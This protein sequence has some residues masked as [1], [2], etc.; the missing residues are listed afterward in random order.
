MGGEEGQ[1]V[2]RGNS[3]RHKSSSDGER[4][5]TLEH[6]NQFNFAYSTLACFRMGMWGSAYSGAYMS[7]GDLFLA[8]EIEVGV[9][10]RAH[11]DD[12]GKVS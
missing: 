12:G 7:I 8:Q 10:P 3:M 2:L 6:R 11:I 5:P 4:E 9:P 1:A